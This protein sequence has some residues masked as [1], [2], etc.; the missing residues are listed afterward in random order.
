M[1]TYISGNQVVFKHTCPLEQDIPC[2]SSYL[3]YSTVCFERRGPFMD[4]LPLFTC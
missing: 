1:A 3:Q 2:Q 4:E